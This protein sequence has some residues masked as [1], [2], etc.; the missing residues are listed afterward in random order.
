MPDTLLLK[1]TVL[2]FGAAVAVAWLFRVLRAPSV[3]GFLVSGIVI[4]PSGLQLITQDTVSQFA[5]LGLVMLLFAVG[6]ELSPGPLLR[7][8]HRII[9]GAALQ[10]A[11]TLLV[12]LV[13]IKAS[14]PS[15][16]T[17]AFALA[18]AITPSSVAI[19]L[20]PLADMRQTDSAMGRTITGVSLVQDIMVI[21][22]MLFLPLLAGPGEGGL[23]AGLLRG[24]ASLTGLAVAAVV[25]R[26]VLPLITNSLVRVGGQE[27]MALFAVMMACAGAWLAARAG[28]APAL[29]ACIAGMLLAETD[30][31]HQLFA[32]IVPFRDVFNA[33]FFMS[34][35]MLVD[36][37]EAS[38]QLHWIAAAVVVILVIKT[39]LAALAVRIAGWPMRLAIQVGLGLASISEFGFVLAREAASMNLFPSAAMN[40]LTAIIVGTMILGTPLVPLAH[41]ISAI[42]LA[43]AS[44]ARRRG[45]PASTDSNLDKPLTDAPCLPGVDVV[46]VGYGLNGQNLA[47]VLK[48]T[49]IGFSIVEMNPALASAARADGWRVILG[50]ATRLSILLQAG[51]ASARA[52]VVAIHDQPATR[53]IVAQARAERPDLFILA[54]TRNVAELDVLHRL[55]AQ[56]VIPEEFETSI[57]I[58]AHVLHHFGI[59]D[60]VIEAQV[61]MVRA[62][63][64]G[65]MRG[66]P[67]TAARRAELIQLFDA[68]ATQTFLL[69]TDSPVLGRSI[70]EVDLRAAT[71]VSIIA[72]VRDGKPA[73]NP[74]PDWTFAAGDLL[75]LLGGHKQLDAAKA[76]FSPP[77]QDESTVQP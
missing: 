63:Q 32:D 59:A 24:A 43:S 57:E 77:P 66:L 56:Q 6:L 47:R 18:L 35:G 14:T 22:L 55:G 34:M 33:L 11:F 19:V 5:E 3:V 30:I 71:G 38:P 4:G 31:K 8:G 76:L 62:G 1:Q 42:F 74:G 75:I 73:T 21:S 48:A 65:M 10:I 52:L 23:A 69:E 13:L 53:R 7:T 68:T 61:A 64:Y 17:V 51:L 16:W 46:I 37:P 29:G 36:L 58:F 67:D 2:L 25:L 15:S 12:G 28:W 39:L 9:L 70:R 41:R 20:K 27:L 26:Y 54:R 44:I 72:I 49:G 40:V 50:D 60:N 45:E